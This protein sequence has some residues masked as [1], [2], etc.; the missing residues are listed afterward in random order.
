MAFLCTSAE[1][2]FDYKAEKPKAESEM[3]KC[4]FILTMS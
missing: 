2:G 1:S 3:I 4:R